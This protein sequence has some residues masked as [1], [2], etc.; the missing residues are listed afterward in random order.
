MEMTHSALAIY[1]K[2]CKAA[3]QIRT[4]AGCLFFMCDFVKE[5]I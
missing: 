4:S 2:A 3:P 1:Y 5:K